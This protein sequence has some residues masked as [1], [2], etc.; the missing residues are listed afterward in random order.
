M[1]RLQRGAAAQPL[2][3]VNFGAGRQD[4]I[5]RVLRLPFHLGP[6]RRSV[7]RRDH[8]V[9]HG[10]CAGVRGAHRADPAHCALYFAKLQGRRFCLWCSMC[11]HLLLS[12][13]GKARR[14]VLVA[15]ARGAV[16][17]GALISMLPA[18]AG[19]NAVWFAMPLPRRRWR[20]GAAALMGRCTKALRR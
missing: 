4:R 16:L 10:V 2:I 13:G 12:G 19:P 1:L 6:V 17:S 3:S 14:G 7:D 20:W 15:A 8:R 11:F 5:R 9:S 18:L